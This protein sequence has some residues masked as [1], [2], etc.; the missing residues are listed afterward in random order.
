MYCVAQT[1]VISVDSFHNRLR[2]IMFKIKSSATDVHTVY[3]GT[4][5]LPRVLSW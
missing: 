2:S 5:Q 3:L 4:G 1:L